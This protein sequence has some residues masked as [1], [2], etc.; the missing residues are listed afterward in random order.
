MSLVD[1]EAS[2]PIRVIV[3]DDHA[4]SRQQLIRALER[5]PRLVVVGQAEDGEEAV[6]LVRR[7]G[8]DVALLDVR[9]P[10]LDG[11]D[12]A[13]SILAGGGPPVVLITSYENELYHEAAQDIGAAA[14]IP[15]SIRE[16]ELV[17]IVLAAAEAEQE[18]EEEDGA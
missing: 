11:L 18:S 15:K 17:E 16:E 5:H 6:D 12:A 8:V 1:A 13:R 10:G 4:L 3:A 9:M 7:G 14:L 2:A